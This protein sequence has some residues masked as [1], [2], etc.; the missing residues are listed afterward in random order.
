MTLVIE[1]A[2]RELF[3]DIVDDMYRFRH[4]IFVGML[5][6]TDIAR[7]DGR[8]IDA[9]DHE[10]AVYFAT[11][12]NGEV[13]ACSRLVPSLTP[14]ICATQFPQYANLR[15]IPRGP[16]IYDYSRFAVAADKYAPAE[17]NRLK[18][19]QVASV[20]DYCVRRSITSC[21]SF[22]LAHTLPQYVEMGIKAVPLGLPVTMG[23][24]TYVSVHFET[25]PEAYAKVL[26]LFAM[27]RSPLIDPADAGKRE[28]ANFAI[29]TGGTR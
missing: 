19:M 26:R 15:G 1:P 20:F 24:S 4:R 7:E 9:Y 11:V 29:R 13:V 16:E 17:C 10:H 18:A 22:T 21:I 8:D 12:E 5:G 14:N 28:R 3:C 6:W 25:T 23:D 27:T 2:Y